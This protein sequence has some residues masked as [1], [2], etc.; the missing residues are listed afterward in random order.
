MEIQSADMGRK[1]AKSRGAGLG[2]TLILMVFVVVC[3]AVF[4]ALSFVTAR[5]DL[6]LSEKNTTA[7]EVYYTA[8]AAAQ[9]KLAQIDDCLVQAAGKTGNYTANCA[10]LLTALPNLVYQAGSLSQPDKVAFEIKVDDVRTLY[11]ELALKSQAEIYLNEK[12]NELRAYMGVSSGTRSNAVRYNV[13][14]YKT[15]NNSAW[16]TTSR[17]EVWPGQ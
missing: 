8:D 4:S 14:A 7:L 15:V 10:S 3:L 5:A 2:G 12:A 11:V 1:P 16:E 6:A 17:I 9:A 13:T